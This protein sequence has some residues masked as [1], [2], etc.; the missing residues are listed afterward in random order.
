MYGL[1]ARFRAGVSEGKQQSTVR[2][3]ATDDG[4]FR[5]ERYARFD[6]DRARRLQEMLT[7]RHGAMPEIST[8]ESIRTEV[9]E[10]ES[11]IDR[12]SVRL[13]ADPLTLNLAE[14]IVK[15][16]QRRETSTRDRTDR[17]PTPRWSHAC[18]TCRRPRNAGANSS[19]ASS[20]W[21]AGDARGVA[22]LRVP[23]SRRLGTCGPRQRE[24]ARRWC[25]PGR[26]R[27]RRSVSRRLP[28]ARRR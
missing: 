21:S 1:S 4:P 7:R 10:L 19:T 5:A 28:S 3:T 9:I 26:S 6:I 12:P 2:R 27:G 17:D 15:A 16:M 11:V 13:A 25:R 24:C 8:E 22:R 18:P 20:A 23:R 14:K